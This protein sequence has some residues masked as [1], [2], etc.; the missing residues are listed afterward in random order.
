MLV[1]LSSVELSCFL[2]PTQPILNST[3]QY[4]TTWRKV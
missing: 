2:R 3:T 1:E 4:D